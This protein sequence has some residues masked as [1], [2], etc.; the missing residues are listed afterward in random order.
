MLEGTVTVHRQQRRTRGLN[1]HVVL[2]RPVD[3]S[4]INSLSVISCR[5]REDDCLGRL[6]NFCIFLISDVKVKFSPL[7]TLEALRVVR[8]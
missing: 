8:G 1:L 3:V 4:A 6:L 2:V 5:F 7:Q